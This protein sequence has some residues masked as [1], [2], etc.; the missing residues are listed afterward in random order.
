MYIFVCVVYMYISACAVH[1]GN[2]LIASIQLFWIAEK[3]R[4][5]IQADLSWRIN[6]YI[7][8]HEAASFLSV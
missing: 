3:T 7:Y 2:L 5:A 8:M 1:D 4:I 6:R